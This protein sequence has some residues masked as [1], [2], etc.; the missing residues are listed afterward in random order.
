[1]LALIL[2]LAAM[3]VLI[4]GMVLFNILTKN[5]LERPETQN[6]ENE[7][8]LKQEKQTQK[9]EQE[10][11]NAPAEESF[12]S[13]QKEGEKPK[14]AKKSAKVDDSKIKDLFVQKNKGRKKQ[15]VCQS[16]GSTFDTYDGNGRCP[17]CG[18]KAVKK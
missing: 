13:E 16:C 12:E 10:I 7:K 8:G 18:A 4:G 11:A 5:K 9:A 6:S 2:L 3:A 1:M 17:Y 15:I 14:K